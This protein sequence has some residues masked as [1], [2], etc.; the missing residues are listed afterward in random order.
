VVRGL[1]DARDVPLL[2][3]RCSNMKYKAIGKQAFVVPKEIGFSQGG[4]PMQLHSAVSSFLP[5]GYVLF[6]CSEAVGYPSLGV[7]WCL[8]KINQHQKWVGNNLWEAS[9]FLKCL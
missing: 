4:P 3:I 2:G 7:I 6:R 9:A 5:N 8:W 1:Q